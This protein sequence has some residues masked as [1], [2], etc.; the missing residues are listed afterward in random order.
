MPPSLRF[1]HPRSID[2]EPAPSTV[3]VPPLR[4]SHETGSVI[5]EIS[6]TL[7]FHARVPLPGMHSSNY[8]TDAIRSH[9]HLSS[10]RVIDVEP[11]EPIEFDG[12][13]FY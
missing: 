13:G 1:S 10:E 4:P 12:S 5:E 11:F 7:R 3:L 9:V 8:A 2:R 6:K